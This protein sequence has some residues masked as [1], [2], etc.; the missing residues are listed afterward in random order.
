MKTKK[1]DVLSKYSLPTGFEVEELKKKEKMTI[2]EMSNITFF[3][4]RKIRKMIKNGKIRAEKKGKQWI[5]NTSDLL[6][7]LSTLKEEIKKMKYISK[8]DK[9]YVKV[10]NV[11]IGYKIRE[12]KEE[13]DE[14]DIIIDYI[15]KYIITFTEVNGKKISDYNEIMY[16]I[17][18]ETISGTIGKIMLIFYNGY[19]VNYKLR[20]LSYYILLNHLLEV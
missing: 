3:S 5:A 16:E 15:E 19:M 1:V 7:N 4:E 14:E 8:N 10:G 6:R 11:V 20:F 13:K 9:T 12:I 18:Y 17:T 2:K